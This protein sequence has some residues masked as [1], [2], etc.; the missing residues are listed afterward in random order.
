M[1]QSSPIAP[2][3]LLAAALASTSILAVPLAQA[4]EAAQAAPAAGQHRTLNLAEL[5]TRRA[6]Q[7]ALA[8]ADGNLL[9]SRPEFLAAAADHPRSAER[10]RHHHRHRIAKGDKAMTQAQREAH[11]DMIF[12]RMDRDASGE[13]SRD[14]AS[15]ENRRAAKRELFAEHRFERLDTDADGVLTAQ[16]FAAPLDRLSAADTNQDGQLSRDERREARAAH[17]GT[18]RGAQPPT[19]S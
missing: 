10:K 7:F 19:R 9:L 12:D 8:D 16:E 15:R 4:R 1:T 18:L 13:L 5:A 2:Q 17:R 6:E 3:L 14:E 11:A